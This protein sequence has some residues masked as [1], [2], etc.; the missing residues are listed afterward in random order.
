M[1]GKLLGIG[2]L[3]AAAT[4]V[5]LAF[6]P[7]VL[8]KKLIFYAAAYLVLKGG[9][10]WLSGDGVSFID[11]LCGAYIIML[12]IGL[13][14]TLISVLAVIFLVQKNTFLFLG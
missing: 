5:M 3:I 11:V 8:P 14:V 1:I 13:S 7:I 10:F 6:T 2:D 4:I 9:L 12:S